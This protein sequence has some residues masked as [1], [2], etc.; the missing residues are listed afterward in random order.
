MR[1][2]NRFCEA[3]RC[4]VAFFIVESA[5]SQI[6]PLLGEVF[7]KLH[8]SVFDLHTTRPKGTT[9]CAKADIMSKRKRSDLEDDAPTP[10]PHSKTTVSQHQLTRFRSTIEQTSKSLSSALK[11]ARGFE[12]QKL[13]RRQKNAS[14]EPQS[15]LRLREEVIILKQLDLA[16]TASN[17]L[18]K[19]L[20]K[21]KRVRE[22]PCFLMV[23]GTEPKLEGIA[24][25]AE[26]N[27]L[28]K[29]FNSNPV[30]EAMAKGMTG[31]YAVLGIE[32]SSSK[33]V[34][35]KRQRQKSGPGTIPE[36]QAAELDPMEITDEE[37]PDQDDSFASFSDEEEDQS[38][39]NI[40]KPTTVPDEDDSDAISASLSAHSISD[41]EISETDEEPSPQ[42]RTKK[43]TRA[44]PPPQPN[45]TSTSSF[46]PALSMGG[47]YDPGPNSESESDSDDHGPALPKERN[48]RRG[49]RARQQIAEA[50]YGS[51]AK[52]LGKPGRADAGWDKRK[53]AVAG[54]GGGGRGRGG[55]AT[56]GGSRG[57]GRGGARGSGANSIAQASRAPRAGKKDDDGPVHPSWEAAKQR[58]I[59]AAGA[60]GKG[61]FEGKKITFD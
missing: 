22:S 4:L 33:T 40:I 32:E 59:Q 43:K 38:H 10:V 35:Q 23:Y 55:G 3:R 60:A 24:S 39:H 31:I 34:K 18:L 36:E 2:D 46:L 7:F 11:L 26:G 47:Y 13:G 42:P 1:Q 21:A 6:W 14:S 12:R 44:L 25:T 56:R 50:K 57:R 27:V 49:Q 9:S 58:K 28:A 37:E 61:V 15:L 16:K 53:G 8:R 30:K 48:N 52:H 29:L 41:S 45:T 17:H 19:T 5:K 20:G 54:P 51:K